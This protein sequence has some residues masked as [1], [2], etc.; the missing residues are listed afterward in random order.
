MQ[1]G[2]KLA[3]YNFTWPVTAADTVRQAK[4]LRKPSISPCSDSQL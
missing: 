2:D 4:Q 3:I 1:V